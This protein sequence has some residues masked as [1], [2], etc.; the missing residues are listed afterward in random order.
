MSAAN[1]PPGT[2]LLASSKCPFCGSRL[3][4][5]RETASSGV[6][7][8]RGFCTGALGT[9]YGT[10]YQQ[11]VCAVGPSVFKPTR[12]GAISAICRRA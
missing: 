3:D 6:K 10:G 9:G 1:L 8:W 4:V 7:G 12:E 2:L 5:R 11:P